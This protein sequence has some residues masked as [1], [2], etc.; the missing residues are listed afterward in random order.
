MVVVRTP[1]RS[2]PRSVAVWSTRARWL[3]WTDGLAGWL[4]LWALLAVML[5]GAGVDLHVVGAG[6]GALLVALV[7]GLRTRWRPVTACVG[8]VVS[9]RLRPGDRAWYVRPGDVERVLV[10]G[11][12]LLR[13]VIVTRERGA[14]E[15]IT[16]RRTRVLL[17]PESDAGQR[18]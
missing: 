14:S 15:G 12:R 8:L 7:P 18:L 16:V 5:P 10:T 4:A 6:A 9:R 3:R 11:R 13:L 17:I 2:L 1:I